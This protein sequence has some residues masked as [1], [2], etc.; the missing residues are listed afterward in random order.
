MTTEHSTLTAYFVLVSSEAALTRT[1]SD[2]QLA[3]RAVQ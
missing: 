3:N 2:Y 1:G